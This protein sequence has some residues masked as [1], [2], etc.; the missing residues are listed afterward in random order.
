MDIVFEM[1]VI[2]Q[3]KSTFHCTLFEDSN[4]DLVLTTTSGYIPRNKHIGVK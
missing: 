1:S 4:W 3:Q 2:F